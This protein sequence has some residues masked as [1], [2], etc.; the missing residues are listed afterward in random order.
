VRAAPLEAQPFAVAGAVAQLE[1]DVE[2]ARQLYNSARLRD[3]RS[4]AVRLLLADLELR[5]GKT[6]EG[7]ANL[8]AI[9]RLSPSISSPVVPALAQF[10][11]SPGAI[12]KIR[13]AFIQNPTL[14]DAVL[15]ELAADP[16][17]ARLIFSLAQQDVRSRGALRPWQQRLVDSTLAAGNVGLAR[18]YWSRFNAVRNEESLVYNASFEARPASPPFNWAL[19]TGSAGMA[20]FSPSGGLSIVHFGREPAQLARQLILPAPGQYSVRSEF[21]GA[22]ERGRLEW[23][24]Q[25]LDGT[26]AQVLPA[27]VQGSTF[28]I[29]QGCSGA[30]LDLYAVPSDTEA[31]LDITLRRVAVK[32]IG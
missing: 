17:N 21:L 27:D 1:G 13:Q 8:I 28:R 24:V 18:A 6:E 32:R 23:R 22:L 16:S 11:R 2:R 25:C 10:A 14:S 3:P 19:M 12:Q 9:A 26:Q 30:W 20:E 4:P 7:L 5:N 29:G 15:N 31:R